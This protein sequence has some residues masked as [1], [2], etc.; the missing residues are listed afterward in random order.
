MAANSRDRILDAAF[1]AFMKNGYA[2]ASM[3][4]IATRARVPHPIGREAV[5]VPAACGHLKAQPDADQVDELPVLRL[6]NHSVALISIDTQ[7]DLYRF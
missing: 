5:G 2:T 3:L 7:P 1:R 6:E 4:E